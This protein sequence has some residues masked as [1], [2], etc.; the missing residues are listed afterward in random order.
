MRK[1]LK[2]SLFEKV[3]NI[4][5]RS[6]SDDASRD[7]RVEESLGGGVEISGVG[8]EFSGVATAGVVVFVYVCRF[9]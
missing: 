1:L 6:G 7:D 2:D 8:V 3:S 5:E 9:T 4:D